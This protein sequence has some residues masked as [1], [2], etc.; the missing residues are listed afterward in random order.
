MSMDVEANE[1]T[2]ESF[3]ALLY[4]QTEKSNRRGEWE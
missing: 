1:I 2:A 3:S 4:F